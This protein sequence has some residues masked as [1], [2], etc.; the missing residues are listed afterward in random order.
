MYDLIIGRL[1]L[2]KCYEIF[3]KYFA[4]IPGKNRRK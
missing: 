3:K 4:H 1:I 2:V